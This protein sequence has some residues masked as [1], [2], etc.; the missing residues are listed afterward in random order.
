MEWERGCILAG[1]LGSMR[2]RLEQAIDHARHRKQFG[3]P[4]GKFQAVA[5]RIAEMR[6]RLDACR[7]LVYRIGRLKDRGQ[8]AEL[9]A[10][11]AKLFV[12]EAHVAS[13]LDAM[14]VFGGYGYMVEQEIERELRDSLG[15]I[16]YS[17]TSDIQRNNIA[18]ALKL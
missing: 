12:S 13:S 10:A 2:R 5:H 8:P 11:I 9:E 1:V 6:V 18:R 4:I 3:K 17:G 14:R 7:P 16:F 15:G